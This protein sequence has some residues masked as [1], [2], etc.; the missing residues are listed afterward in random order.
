MGVWL[1]DTIRCVLVNYESNIQKSA[2]YIVISMGKFKNQNTK[3]TSNL[4][5]K[6]LQMGTSCADYFVDY[7]G[8]NSVELCHARCFQRLHLKAENVSSESSMEVGRYQDPS[9]VAQTI[10]IDYCLESF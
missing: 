1:S 10:I 9:N 7:N 8:S 6:L 4:F 2:V 5:S 3:Q